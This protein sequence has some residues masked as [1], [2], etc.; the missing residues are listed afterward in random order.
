MVKILSVLAIS[1]LALTVFAQE[2]GC[3]GDAMKTV[4][5][6]CKA[7]CEAMKMCQDKMANMSCEQIKMQREDA[8]CDREQVRECLP[9]CDKEIM[10]KA[11]KAKECK[12]IK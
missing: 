7:N 1:A 10:D 12:D 4:G 8:A 9:A 6:A 2:P 3:G 5:D 11:D